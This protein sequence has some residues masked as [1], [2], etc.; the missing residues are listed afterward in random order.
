VTVDGQGA[1]ALPR[2]AEGRAYVVLYDPL[3]QVD[4]ITLARD[5]PN[6]DHLAEIS[7]ERGWGQWSI[8]GW[9]AYREASGSFAWLPVA[10][11]LAAF[12]VFGVAIYHAWGNRQ[13]LVQ[14]IAVIVTRYRAVDDRIALLI[15][16]GAA[17][18]S[19]VMVG[20]IPTLGALGLL[21]LLLLLRPEMGL[22]LIAF[23]LPFYQLGRPFLGRVF[24]MV[25]I[26]TILSALG[27][28]VSRVFG[29]WKPGDREQARDCGDGA[30]GIALHAARLTK[31]D[32]GVLAL[33]IAGAISLLWSEHGRVAAREFRT[34]ILGASI[35]YGLLRILVPTHEMT[36]QVSR[37]LWRVVDAWVLGGALIAL[38]GVFQWT[39]GQN[40]ITAEGVWRV[41]GF[42]GSPNNLALYLG[43]IFPVA[44]VVG[45]WGQAG[46]RR[47]AYGAAAL[48]MATAIFMTYSRGAWVIGVPASLLF[49]AALRGRRTLVIAAGV[50]AVIAILVFFAAGVERLTSLL[51]TSVGTTFFRLQLWQSS[52]AMIQDHPLLGVGL[53]NFLYAYRT[54]YVLPTAWEEFNLSHPHNVVLD[55]WLRLGLPGLLVLLWLVVG[56]FRRGWR[57]YRRLSE[58]SGRLLALG[59]MAG[60]VNLLAHGL[61]DNAFFLVDLAF[62]FM[63]FLALVQAVKVGSGVVTDI[64]G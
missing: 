1:N 12:L 42:Y 47:W 32:W 53:D 25:E 6:G 40:V 35:L 34:V 59:L 22:P 4:T 24:S 8:V 27:W 10:F 19:Y 18:L 30:E 5:L 64:S 41:R 51:D 48:L 50:V 62:T 15:T 17:V 16:G 55:F 36:G 63:L 56:F 29:I 45:V 57:S 49:L 3:R 33:V 37:G 28:V 58:S 54:R 14:S 7:A 44:I 31:L 46:R 52:W 61:V 43:K 9:A 39:L 60:M 38:L 20:T 23:A 2:D 21:A 26:L 13:T 11:G